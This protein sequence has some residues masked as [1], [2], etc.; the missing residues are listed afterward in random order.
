M[1]ETKQDNLQRLAKAFPPVMHLFH[2]LAGEF[3][4]IGEFTL[5]QYRVLMLVYHR[6]PMSIKTLMRQL[7]I[8]QSSASGMVDRLVQQGLLQLQKD[9]A[10]KRVT[11]FELSAPARL[12]LKKRMNAMKQVYRKVLEPLDAAQQ[13]ELI[14]A[15]ET[16]LRL[17]TSPDSPKH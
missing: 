8:A 11:V 9:P 3:S 14:S 5:A 16:I 6:G 1:N 2:H 17:T 15:F 12:L 4:K 10:D 7:N 13:E